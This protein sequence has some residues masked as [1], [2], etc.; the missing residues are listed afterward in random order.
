[1]TPRVIFWSGCAL[2]L[3][4]SASARV[5]LSDLVAA[6]C[7]S[8][9]TCAVSGWDPALVY[10]LDPDL[11]E[12]GQARGPYAAL[13][14]DDQAQARRCLR[15]LEREC[16]FEWIA[17]GGGDWLPRE[18]AAL[19]RPGTAEA[20][21]PCVSGLQC[22]EGLACVAV[23]RTCASDER[24]CGVADEGRLADLWFVDTSATTCTNLGCREA[25][26]ENVSVREGGAC[27]A[28][29]ETAWNICARGLVCGAGQT[30]RRP[31]A[32]GQPCE[33]DLH[34][35][36]GLLCDEVCRRPALG[37]AVGAPCFAER[38]T[39][40]IRLGLACMRAEDGLLRC[41]RA[42]DLGDPCVTRPHDSCGSGLMCHVVDGC[43]PTPARRAVGAA[44][45]RG[46]ECLS[47]RCDRATERCVAT[48]DEG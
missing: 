34:C 7:A 42:T 19:R 2:I 21:T 25:V 22:A 26:Y 37:T 20:G 12:S 24:S 4:C 8:L 40:D 48:C 31:A 39:C 44:C 18:C 5:E 23:T 11:C 16:P 32:E 6:H 13:P 17:R 36:P 10:R 29:S 1:M 43:T 41:A 35:G 9:S 27:G 46:R 3:G 30:C 14:L 38:D 33:D 28:S 47:G 45:Q 15:A